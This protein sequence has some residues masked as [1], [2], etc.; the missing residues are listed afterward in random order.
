M[1]V[2]DLYRMHNII[3]N[4]IKPNVYTTSV[5]ENSVSHALVTTTTSKHNRQTPL[6]TIEEF[7]WLIETPT[8]QIC[9]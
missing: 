7:L 1:G 4:Q 9:S 6:S 3:I 5:T 8:A 2:L